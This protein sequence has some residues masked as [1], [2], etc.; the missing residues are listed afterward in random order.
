MTKTQVEV[1]TSVQRRRS[2]SRAEKERIVAAAMEP[3]AVDSE[4]ARAAGIHTSQLFRWR[5]QLCERTR[6]PAA[7]NPVAITPEPEAASAP[8]VAARAGV[9]ER[10]PGYLAGFWLLPLERLVCLFERTHPVKATPQPRSGRD[11][12]RDARCIARFHSERRGRGEHRSVGP[13]GGVSKRFCRRGQGRLRRTFGKRALCPDGRLSRCISCIPKHPAARQ[14]S[15]EALQ[16]SSLFDHG[17]RGATRS[18][19]APLLLLFSLA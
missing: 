3:G 6:V 5:Q 11:A 8:P 10:L 1:I 13:A 7:F 14:V 19:P 15:L 16:A 9:I 4:V 12:P 18:S 2:W 17:T